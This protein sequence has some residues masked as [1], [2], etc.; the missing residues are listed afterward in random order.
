MRTAIVSASFGAEYGRLTEVTFPTIR[1]YA[2][3]IGACFIPIT[4]RILPAYV[5]PVWEKLQIRNVLRDFERVLWVD[6]DAI[7]RVDAPD[8]FGIVPPSIFGAYNEAATK[9]LDYARILRRYCEDAGIEQVPFRGQYFNAGIM[10]VGRV[11]APLFDD[12][13]YFGG[14][15]VFYDQ[16][17]LNAR[18]ALGNYPC[19]DITRKFNHMF[20]SPGHRLDSYVV[21]YAGM[22]GGRGTHDEYIPK[23][24]DGISLVEMDKAY[25]DLAAAEGMLDGEGLESGPDEDSGELWIPAERFAQAYPD[26]CRQWSGQ[27][28]KRQHPLIAGK[29]VNLGPRHRRILH[30]LER[31][32]PPYGERMAGSLPK[33][34]YD[35]ALQ[36][37]EEHPQIKRLLYLHG[38]VREIK[39]KKV[40][41]LGTGGGA[42]ALFTL[43]AMRPDGVLITADRGYIPP[44]W[45]D[46]CRTDPRLKLVVGHDRDLSA[47]RGLDVS[48]VDLLLLDAEPRYAFVIKKWRLL[49]PLLRPGATAVIAGIRRNAEMER[50]WS[51]LGGP[52]L[53]IGPVI[54]P[55]GSGL[56][57]A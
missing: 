35:A 40:L 44:R 49:R 53:D 38:L 27:A 57:I 14:E 24:L 25:W 20:L 18:I 7:V 16:T 26:L 28:P 4:E 8:L 47:F 48:N 37:L 3:R 51:E 45:L 54:Y 22:T 56:K 1:A 41:Q 21:H 2:E 10:V 30:R 34:Q 19:Q 11:H 6:G 50:F 43:L 17:C 42:E 29:R 33:E 32:A 15:E 5:S 52:K 9:V 46:R 39:P 31:C 55:T 23:G 13:P 36:N 12:P